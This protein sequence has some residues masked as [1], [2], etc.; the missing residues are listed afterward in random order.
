MGGRK[1]ER[2]NEER[3]QLKKRWVYRRKGEYIVGRMKIRKMGG[4]KDQ[5]K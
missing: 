5:R 4:R 1:E 2:E 3:R